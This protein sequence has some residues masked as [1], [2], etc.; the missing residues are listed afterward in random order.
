MHIRWLDV[1][2]NREQE[3]KNQLVFIQDLATANDVEFDPSRFRRPRR[4][5]KGFRVL[6]HQSDAAL[7]ISQMLFEKRKQGLPVFNPWSASW[8]SIDESKVQR[9]PFFFVPIIDDALVNLDDG[10][11]R[12][13]VFSTR[14]DQSSWIS[15]ESGITVH[16]VCKQ[17][18]HRWTHH[19]Y[20]KVITG[21]EKN[22]DDL[23]S[24]VDDNVQMLTRLKC[25][26][27]GGVD[28]YKAGHVI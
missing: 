10:K 24:E 26:Y 6:W 4:Y 19:P 23:I 14:R 8:L 7:Y 18:L 17:C 11:I 28:I 21:E 5:F 12:A 22:P 20:R 9:Q 15:I 27:C 13:Y 16:A 25:P 1:F 3:W 2:R